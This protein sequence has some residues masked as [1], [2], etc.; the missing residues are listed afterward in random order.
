MKPLTA[1]EVEGYLKR[2]GYRLDRIRGSHHVWVNDAVGV[3]IPAPHH[4]NTP[5]KQGILNGIFNFAGIPKSLR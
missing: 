1:R 2:Y 3:S 4:G 5:L